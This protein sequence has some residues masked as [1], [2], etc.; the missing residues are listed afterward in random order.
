MHAPKLALFALGLP[1]LSLGTGCAE[2]GDSEPE[3]NDQRVTPGTPL[4]PL[5]GRQ[6]VMPE[7]TVPPGEERAICWVPKWE[8]DRDYLVSDF[9]SYQG[10][11]GHHLFAFTSLIPRRAGDTFDCTSLQS[12]STIKPLLSVTEAQAG[13]EAAGFIGLPDDF[14]IRLKQGTQIVFQSHYINTSDKL[15]K[16]SDV[17]E[18]HY[19]DPDE[20]HVE[21]NYFVINDGGI[22]L[23]TGASTRHM[24]CTVTEQL[25]IKLLLGHMHDWGTSITLGLEREGVTTSLLEVDK[26]LAEYRDIPPMANYD[27]DAPL[28][29][30]PG[31]RIHVTCSYDNN[32]S[33]NLLFPQEMCVLFSAY[34]PAKPEGFISCVP[35]IVTP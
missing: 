1:F 30:E 14:V 10:S 32:T 21:F 35:E 11:M 16:V 23:P 27:R 6:F 17:G 8:P 3:F 26:W 29:L 22:D 7:M 12:M 2:T 18:F 9:T 34:F 19:F 5:L 24:V 31:D 4:D 25:Q 15:I 13:G 33:G 28:L 20:S